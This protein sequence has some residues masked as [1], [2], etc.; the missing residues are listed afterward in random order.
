[1]A[2][3]PMTCVYDEYVLVGPVCADNPDEGVQQ[4]AD[5]ALGSHTGITD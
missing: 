3:T 4:G 5:H 2:S 1:M